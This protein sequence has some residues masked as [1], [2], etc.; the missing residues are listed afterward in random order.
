MSETRSYRP[1]ETASLEAE[2]GRL[3]GLDVN[4][5]RERASRRS[6][7]KPIK[8][9]KPYGGLVRFYTT[10][11]PETRLPSHGGVDDIADELPVPRSR[12]NLRDGGLVDLKVENSRL[13]AENNRLVD[14][15]DQIPILRQKI[16]EQSTQIKKFSELDIAARHEKELKEVSEAQFLAGFTAGYEY[17]TGETL[18]TPY[19][20][21]FSR[22]GVKIPAPAESA[23]PP[24]SSGTQSYHQ[25]PPSSQMPQPAPMPYPKFT[26]FVPQASFAPQQYLAYSGPTPTTTKPPMA[27]GSR[28]TTFTQTGPLKS[29]K[30]TQTPALVNIR[31]TQT[32]K[33]KGSTCSGDAAGAPNRET[34]AAR[35]AERN[36]KIYLNRKVDL[37]PA[38]PF[39]DSP[40]S[41]Q[42]VRHGDSVSDDGSPAVSYM[43]MSQPPINE[44]ETVD[45]G[46]GCPVKEIPAKPDPRANNDDCQT[47][48]AP[49]VQEAHAYTPTATGDPQFVN[50]GSGYTEGLSPRGQ[51]AHD[52]ND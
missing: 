45:G 47:Y 20:A 22:H 8:P 3:Y 12:P 15:I 16:K 28:T 43:S 25:P 4:L 24:Q 29:A 32:P 52:G 42:Q 11:R 27:A 10:P 1:F 9:T 41:G 14:E 30:A 19:P 17:A 26:S 2:Y 38:H 31:A 21:I 50:W 51:H 18:A 13:Q 5:I 49:T 6:D 33:V 35:N 46:G 23:P 39:D 36:R 34:A 44:M 7:A 37:M 48:R 40:P